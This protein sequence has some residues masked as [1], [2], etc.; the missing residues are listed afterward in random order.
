M[1]LCTCLYI[2]LSICSFIESNLFHLWLLEPTSKSLC[3]PELILPGCMHLCLLIPL[4]LLLAIYPLF[5]LVV[6]ICYKYIHTYIKCTLFSVYLFSKILNM[7]M[8]A[9]SIVPTCN[10]L[11]SFLSGTFTLNRMFLL[12]QCAS[13]ILC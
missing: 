6:P 4:Y 7:P 11:C 10:Y 3:L 9:G 1:L 2:L 5:L 12:P 8:L 13:F